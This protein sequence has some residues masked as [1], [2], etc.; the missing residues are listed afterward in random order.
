MNVSIVR[1]SLGLMYSP[2]SK[3][4]TS[5]AICRRMKKDQIRV[6]RSTR[7]PSEQVGPGLWNRVAHGTSHSPNRSQ[8]R[9]DGSWQ[10]GLLVRHRVI[11]GV[12]NSGDFF[13]IL[14]ENFDTELVFECHHQFHGVK[15]VSPR[16]ATKDFSW[17]TWLSST[18]SCSAMIFLTRAS[19]S[20]ICPSEGG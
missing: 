5:P 11:D 10:S 14:I 20:L 16:S 1:A 19:I 4:L 6:I 13:S 12:L 2:K 18:P 3:F 15:G 8:R 17:V 9:G 7:L